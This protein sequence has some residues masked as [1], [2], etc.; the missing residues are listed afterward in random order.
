MTLD[1]FPLPTL[2]DGGMETE[3]VFHHDVDLP[4]FAAYP[5]LRTAQ[6]RS[7]L[8]DYY[9]SYAAVAREHHAGLL[10]ES[11]TW[12]ANPD[13]GAR[14]GDSARD[15]T[16]IN[17][18]AVQWL[19]ELRQGELAD[20]PDVRISGMIGPRGDGYAAGIEDATAAAAYHRAQIDA[21]AEAGA[22]LVTAY[23]LT[24]SGEAVGIV[25]AAR[26]AGI[27]VGI[28]F[29]V[30]TDGRLPDGASLAETIS[31]VDDAA[32]PD[33]YLVNCAHPR[34]IALAVATLGPNQLDRIR[35]LRGN[36]SLLSHAELDEATTLDMGDID[37]FAQAT[38]MLAGLAPRLTIRGGCCGTDVRHVAAA[39]ARRT[40]AT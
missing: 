12:R 17:S 2:T 34:H 20:H 30:E 18:Y 15:L 28:S 36:A 26:S 9:L 24:G 5:L 33:H 31:I 8:R 7:L 39:W 4:E 32:A 22:D 38:A 3:F 40:A 11:P 35:G 14:L 21:F 27:P 23:T 29:T 37:E 25:R 1:L 13:W 6:G 19:R 16:D 10:L